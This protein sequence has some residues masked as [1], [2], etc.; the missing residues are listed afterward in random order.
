MSTR[1]RRN[2]IPP[3][4]PAQVIPVDDR[5]KVTRPEFTIPAYVTISWSV[6]L[7]LLV[8][9]GT[10]HF[11]KVRIPS[12]VFFVFLILCTINAAISGYLI[13]LANKFE[14]GK[15]GDE[16][17]DQ[18]D[19]DSSNPS[20]PADER[21]EN[22]SNEEDVRLRTESKNETQR[23]RTVTRTPAKDFGEIQKESSRPQEEQPIDD[24]QSSPPSKETEV[25]EVKA[26]SEEKLSTPLRS[27]IEQEKKEKT[28]EQIREEFTLDFITDD[29]F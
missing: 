23:S 10:M 28:P 14:E 8:V 4:P 1:Q 15:E 29:T 27:V 13:Y 21:S 19:S 7:L 6:I 22:H 12:I 11:A 24:I 25:E 17:S 3:V 5:H 20:S 9:V 26:K 2:R 18:S 16:E